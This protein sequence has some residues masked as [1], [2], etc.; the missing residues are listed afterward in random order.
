MARGLSL[1]RK[2]EVFSLSAPPDLFDPPFFGHRGGPQAAP[3]C[4]AGRRLSTTCLTAS[5]R[6]RPASG[7]G[8]GHIGV[9]DGVFYSGA[10]AEQVADGTRNSVDAWAVKGIAG[11]GILLDVS[12]AP[13]LGDSGGR[14]P[15]GQSTPI[16]VEDL[17]RARARTGLEF[18]TGDILLLLHAGFVEVVQADA[19]RGGAY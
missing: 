8:L 13:S 11:R 4:A 17:V 12:G 3:C 15:L 2:G 16:T 9:S 19:V 5:S 18:E 6:R 14:S 10:K 7:T 1:A